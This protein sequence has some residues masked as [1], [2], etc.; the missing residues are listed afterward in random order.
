MASVSDNQ[1]I[2]KNTFFLYIRMLLTMG[3]SIYT[4]RIVLE[5]LGE[6]DY[7]IYN[8]IGGVIAMFAFINLA[9]TSATQR[10]LSYAL[11][12]QDQN[13]Y[14]K[15]FNNSV[16]CYVLISVIII[17]L[18]ETIGLWFVN[19]KL[20][21]PI[22]Q[23]YST[24]FVYQ[25]TIV[26]FIINLLRIPFESAIIASEK[27]KFYAYISV[28]EAVLKLTIV[29]L[30]F[31]VPGNKLILY[32]AFMLII[33]LSCNI[34]FQIICNR[35]LKV[36]FKLAFEPILFKKLLSY[37]GW[38]MFGST[39]NVLARQ[40]GNILMNMFFGVLVNAAFGIASQVNAAVA[41]FVGNFQLAFKPQII[42]L[43]AAKNYSELNSLIFKTSKFSYYLTLIIL[44]PI[45]FNIHPILRLW[46]TEVPEW[47]SLFTI[48]LMIYCAIDAIQ[49]PLIVLIYAHD[50]IRNYQLWL[51]TLLFLNIPI[52]YILLKHGFPVYT[53]LCVYVTINFLSAI[54]RTIYVRFF[55]NFPSL[56]Y[57]YKVILPSLLTTIVAF[58]ACY[59]GLLLSNF[60]M[61][62]IC[63]FII[64]SI[65]IYTIGFNR[66]EKKY[67]QNLINNKIC[68]LFYNSSKNSK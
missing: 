39:A 32:S 17:L 58:G 11:G 29:Y 66:S 21:I 61:R 60:I 65:V 6:T 52:S 34:I 54:I 38:A 49:T 33:P 28:L 26:T 47:T 48:L 50:N 14:N 15:I 59:I 51:S 56:E 67:A 31:I 24:N 27:M 19:N 41:K 36:S 23:K 44:I 43:Y 5:I 10:F 53:V 37:T 46:L 55:S 42:K 40:G 35:D 3:V 16:S 20:T 57:T 9:L 62:I 4:T 64:T 18:A 22:D 13:Q 7:G 63:Q 1:R 2:A 12:S 8:V 45:T 68:Q 25:F 30:L